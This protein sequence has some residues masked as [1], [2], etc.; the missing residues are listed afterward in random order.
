MFVINQRFIENSPSFDSELFG[1][2]LISVIY[3]SPILIADLSC[4][5]VAVICDELVFIVFHYFQQ[6]TKS[7]CFKKYT[8]TLHKWYINFFCI[9]LYVTVCW[10]RYIKYSLINTIILS[11]C[12]ESLFWDSSL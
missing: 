6:I 2:R 10:K 7:H 11:C 1:S 9:I 4:K 8:Y 3:F 5:N 12:N